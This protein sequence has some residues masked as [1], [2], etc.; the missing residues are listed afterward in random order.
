MYL[1]SKNNI[2]FW[3]IIVGD[4]ML[5]QIEDLSILLIVWEFH[6]LQ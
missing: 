1:K 6:K 2:S 4:G 5:P 3:F